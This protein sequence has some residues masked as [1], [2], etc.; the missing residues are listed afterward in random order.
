MNLAKLVM[1]IFALAA[2]LSM[3]SIGYAI[4]VQSV[5]GAIAAVLALIVVFLLG[6]TMKRK[7]RNQGL[8]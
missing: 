5:F 6:F 7:F 2:I 8:L 3:V 4:A 1:F